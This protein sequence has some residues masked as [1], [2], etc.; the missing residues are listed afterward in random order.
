MKDRAFDQPRGL[1]TLTVDPEPVAALL[2]LDVF[3]LSPF[4]LL[5]L[6]ALAR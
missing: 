2:V 3:F 6:E 4:E 1:D 5:R